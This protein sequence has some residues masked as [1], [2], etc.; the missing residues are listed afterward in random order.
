[1]SFL[2]CG[3]A[4]NTAKNVKLKKEKICIKIGLKIRVN[5]IIIKV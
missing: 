4:S 5:H 2:W 3:V 1:M